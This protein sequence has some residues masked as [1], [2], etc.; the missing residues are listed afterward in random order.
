M[1]SKTSKSAWELIRF[2]ESNVFA[3][4]VKT[5]ALERST[6]PESDIIFASSRTINTPY[7]LLMILESICPPAAGRQ[8]AGWAKWS[9]RW[10][11]RTERGRRTP[12]QAGD[13]HP[14]CGLASPPTPMFILLA[15]ST[16]IFVL[17]HL[18]FIVVLLVILIC[19][20]YNKNMNPFFFPR[21]KNGLRRRGELINLFWADFRVFNKEP[22]NMY[23]SGSPARFS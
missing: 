9:F 15:S 17:S 3:W 22:C 8:P 12:P 10:W 16:Y 18:Y 2:G 4:K 1:Y 6:L 11:Q 13:S 5:F 14:V 7:G 23:F 19:W 20:N 21:G